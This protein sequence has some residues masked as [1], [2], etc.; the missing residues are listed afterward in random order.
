MLVVV[1]FMNEMFPDMS[2][3]TPMRR[4]RATN[5]RQGEDDDSGELV[6]KRNA[7]MAVFSA[8]VDCTP[9]T[10]TNNNN[11]RNYH[12]EDEEDDESRTTLLKSMSLK[13]F[14][15]LKCDQMDVQRP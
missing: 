15:K 14:L 3:T 4:K 5:L 10:S 6:R 11:N 8:L 13:S 12:E 2:A 1:F 9:S 7:R